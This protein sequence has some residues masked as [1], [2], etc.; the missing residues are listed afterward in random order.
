MKA[1]YIGEFK[2]HSYDTDSHA[3]MSLQSMVK[4]FMET[5][6]DHSESTGHTIERLLSENRGW[7]VLNWIIKFFD[8]PRFK[9]IIK[10]STWTKGGNKLQAT[11]FFVMENEGEVVAEAAT[12]WAFLDLETRH[13]V[14]FSEEVEELYSLDKEPPFDPGK[15]TMPDENKG[16]A[17]SS[18]IITVRRSETD[19]NNHVNN[20]KYIEWA[21]DDIPEEIYENW[22]CKELR[23]LYRKECKMNDN[24]IITSYLMEDDEKTIVTIMKDMN[25][26]ILCKVSTC[27]KERN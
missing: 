17:I 5:S 24:V 16:D 8:Y 14:R 3:K 26:N 4:Y 13:P 10:T 11:R 27:W 21:V 20:I 22:N 12:R 18:R 25:E 15:Y 2:V 1:P 9:D 23:V 7:V 6:I 19:T